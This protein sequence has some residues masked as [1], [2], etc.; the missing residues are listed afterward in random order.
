MSRRLSFLLC[1]IIGNIFTAN[2]GAQVLVCYSGHLDKHQYDWLPLI[3]CA[4]LA[5]QSHPFRNHNGL[6]MNY[7]GIGDILTVAVAF[8]RQ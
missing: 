1:N 5:F 6:C 4:T 3:G 7:L 8:M 2:K